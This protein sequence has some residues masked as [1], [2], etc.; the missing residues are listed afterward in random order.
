LHPYLDSANLLPLLNKTLGEPWRQLPQLDRDRA[1]V[2]V[3]NDFAPL[4]I[5][6]ARARG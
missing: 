4:E 6:D 1:A 2:G 3:Y 5:G